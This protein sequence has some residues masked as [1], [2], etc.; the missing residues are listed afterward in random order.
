MLR[1]QSEDHDNRED[2]VESRCQGSRTEELSE[3]FASSLRQSEVLKRV[4]SVRQYINEHVAPIARKV[5][6]PGRA[7]THVYTWTFSW[8]IGVV[9]SLA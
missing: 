9:V 6:S 2:L 7:I 1:A 8:K 3:C 5:S 4:V